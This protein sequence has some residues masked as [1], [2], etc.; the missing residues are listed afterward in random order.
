M[1]I[2][3]FQTQYCGLTQ[4]I[5]TLTESSSTEL[6]PKSG[7]QHLSHSPASSHSCLHPVHPSEGSLSRGLPS[8]P[9][10]H[11]SQGCH[12]LLLQHWT[13]FT[14]QLPKAAGLPAANHPSVLSLCGVIPFQSLYVPKWHL[15]GKRFGHVCSFQSGILPE[16]TG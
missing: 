14:F 16:N 10:S 4:G 13:V 12:L 15:G 5:T 3:F 11:C 2:S 1:R 6:S 7:P 9:Y 8:L